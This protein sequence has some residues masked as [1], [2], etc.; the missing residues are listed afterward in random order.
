MP[1]LW[2]DS[3]N[4]RPV[5][6]KGKDFFWL[7]KHGV[8]AVASLFHALTRWQF[9]Q[10]WRDTCSRSSDK[11]ARLSQVILVALPLWLLLQSFTGRDGKVIKSKLCAQQSK[12]Q[13]SQ[14]EKGL[15]YLGGLNNC[16]ILRAPNCCQIRG[17]ESRSGGKGKDD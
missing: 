6:A 15:S 11:P 3:Q 13:R 2:H 7:R 5:Q 9:F 1:L 14:S 17:D 16:Q 10:S 12:Q 4:S 8:A